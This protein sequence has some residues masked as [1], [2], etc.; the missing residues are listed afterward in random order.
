MPETSAISCGIT[1]GFQAAVCCLT[2]YLFR[3]VQNKNLIFDVSARVHRWKEVASSRINSVA[4][5]SFPHMWSLFWCWP[6][7]IFYRSWERRDR[8]PTHIWSRH[9]RRVAVFWTSDAQTSRW[10]QIQLRWLFESILHDRWQKT[11]IDVTS[12]VWAWCTEP[13]RDQCAQQYLAATNLLKNKSPLSGK[14]PMSKTRIN[15]LQ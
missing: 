8:T 2:G 13:S 12:V 10:L 14:F 7:L 1:L 4:C 3:P 6:P 5:K 11:N 9:F 15:L